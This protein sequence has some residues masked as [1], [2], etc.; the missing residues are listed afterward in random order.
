[1]EKILVT[2]TLILLA[3]TCISLVIP[4]ERGDRRNV[5]PTILPAVISYPQSST[6]I[7]Q[8]YVEHSSVT[9]LV[10]DLGVGDPSQPRWSINVWNRKSS[11]GNLDLTVDISAAAQYL[12]PSE[13]NRWFL[14]V[15]D[16]AGGNQGQIDKFTIISG[17][18]TFDSTSIPVAIYDFQASYSYIP[19]VPLELAISRR[20]SIRDFPAT[21]NYTFPE[22]S[23]D[24]L[25]KVLWAGYGIS[26]LGRTAANIS[27]NYP[28]VIYVCN[29]T[30]V[31]KYNPTYNRLELF[32][33]GDYRFSDTNP[34]YPGPGTHRAPVELFICLDTNK[35]NDPLL[36]SME[37]GAVIQNM[38]L[39]AN[40]LGLGTV[41]VGGVNNTVVHGMLNLPTNHVVLLNM[42]LGHPT[43]WAFYNFTCVA[44]PGSAGLPTVRQSSIFLDSALAE[45]SKSHDWSEVPLTPRETSQILWSA[46]GRSYLEDMRPG[47][48]SF[49]YQHRTIASASSYPLQ[50]WVM[51][52]TGTYQYDPWGHNIFAKS[53]GDRR[54]ELAQYTAAPWVASSPMTL[55]AVLNT[56]QMY[57]G[58]LWAA[59]ALDWA[60]TEIGSL[61]QDVFLESA[62][63]GLVADWSKI[64]DENAT[65][66]ILGIANF[67]DLRPIIAVTVGH[68]LVRGDINNDGIVDIYDAIILS[69]AFDSTPSSPKWNPKA[70][71][72]SDGFV[73]I[74]DAIILASNFGRTT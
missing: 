43:S 8:I 31:Y 53:L 58:Q 41:C 56:S 51:N 26:S 39:E 17:S 68:P 25:L 22:V 69:N 27:G 60:Y 18:Q 1:M 72:N 5:L 9:D 67:T 19:G 52:S 62:A 63:W 16:A 10:V 47:F 42:P 20:I 30:A 35:S 37:A 54:T 74:Y 23:S 50:I 73:D 13:E 55:L 46:Y 71:I 64:V 40:S 29:K 59:Q 3:C 44:A 15:F 57:Q 11:I 14:R 24:L 65:R 61:I 34:D 4:I 28:L 21:E 36:A 32:K 7:A 70:D 38:Y 45:A 6:A 48:W 12:P 49:Q 2:A 33:Y 66:T